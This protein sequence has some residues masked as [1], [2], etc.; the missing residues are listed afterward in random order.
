MAGCVAKS[1]ITAQAHAGSRFV[2]EVA[3]RLR[4]PLAAYGKL[5]FEQDGQRYCLTTAFFINKR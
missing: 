5:E 1:V 4:G 3:L 2:G